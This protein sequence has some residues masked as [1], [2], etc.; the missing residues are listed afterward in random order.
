[1]TEQIFPLNAWYAAAYD[2]EVGRSLLAR[3][4]CN[5]PIVMYRKTTGEAVALADACW[6]RLVPLSGGELNGD[7]VI[8]PYHGL[9]FD[10][11]GRC[12]YMPSQETINPSACVKSY[13]VVEKHRFV[14]IW[15]GD[16][17]L[18]DPAKVPDMHWIN[19]PEW[20]ADGKRIHVKCDYRLV[21]DNLMDLTHETF[22]HGSSIGNRAVAEA[23]FQTTHT[24][25]TATV[26]RWMIDIDAPPFWAGQLGRKEHVDRWQIIH[27]QAPSTICIEVGVAPTGTGA[28]QGDRSKGVEGMVLNTMTPETDKTCHYFWA[29]ARHYDI[30]NQARTHQLRE[31]VSTVFRED[32][33]VLEAQQKAID[34]NPDHVFY[35]LN[36]DAGS[37]WARKLIQQMIADEQPLRIAAE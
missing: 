35:N 37:M 22:V 1:M 20:A 8:C 10:D 14:W 34:D 21:V 18:A 28:P 23:P 36:I 7:N 3:K 29:F 2:V 11:S 9:E 33:A 16:P 32:E 4:I 6:H 24:D 5:K 26:T 27:F 30:H 25:R 13:P 31:G 17:A 19:D 12:V 15:P